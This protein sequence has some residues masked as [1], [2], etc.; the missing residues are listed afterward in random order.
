MI[1]LGNNKEKFGFYQVGERRTYSKLEAV[2]LHRQ[3][4]IHPHWNFNE[5]FFKGYDWTVEP[6][7]DLETLYA[8]R[9]QQ[10]RDTYDY[11]VV[12][13]SGGVDSDNILN[14]FV[15]NNIQIDEILTYDV[16]KSHGDSTHIDMVELD[17]IGWPKIKSLQDRGVKFKHRHIDLSDRVFQM[18]QDSTLRLNRAYY[19]STNFGSIH[20]N[21]TYMREQE[22]DYIKL[23]ESDKKMVFVWGS[24]KPRIYYENEKFCLKFI[25]LVD[26]SVRARTQ[27][28]N[29]QNE[30]DELFYW[31]PEAVDIICKQGHI[32]KNFFKQFHSFVSKSVGHDSNLSTN[33]PGPIKSYVNEHRGQLLV[34]EDLNYLQEF[35]PLELTNWLIYKNFDPRTWFSVG[36]P[37]TRLI[38]PRETVFNQDPEIN[39][40]VRYITESL[41]S[42]DRYWWNNPDTIVGGMKMCVSPSYYL[43]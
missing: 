39:T 5:E 23:T 15:D 22:P 21:V 37:T 9:A 42:I 28:L 34:P 16:F 35:S 7:D 13:Y 20:L 40:H 41:S 11:V 8:R 43:E 32:L 31:A 26:N 27:M 24:D 30:Y 29:R 19:A 4:G 18:L 12:A 10:I 14:S 38:S 6:K 1:I 17:R 33:N 2:E 36:K 3:T 25:D